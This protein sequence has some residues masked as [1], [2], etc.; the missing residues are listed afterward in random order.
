MNFEG[1]LREVYVGVVL[2]GEGIKTRLLGFQGYLA[3][4]RT[5]PVTPR[6]SGEV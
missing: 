6:T 1:S 5:V 2:A 4:I 3:Q